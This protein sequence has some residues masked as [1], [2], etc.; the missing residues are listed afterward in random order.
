VL[1]AVPAASPLGQEVIHSAFISGEQLARNIWQPIFFAVVVAVIVLMMI[2]WA[3]R[4]AISRWRAQ[5]QV[6]LS[7]REKGERGFNG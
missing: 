7:P 2:E 6:S 4:I 5:K 3:L 1:A